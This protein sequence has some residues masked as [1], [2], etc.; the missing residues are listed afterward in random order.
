MQKTWA[1][2]HLGLI[3][4]ATALVSHQGLYASSY[5]QEWLTSKLREAAVE[6][7]HPHSRP[8]ERMPRVLPITSL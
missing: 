2:K 1:E 3:G 6:A 8:D 4:N 5:V 7:R